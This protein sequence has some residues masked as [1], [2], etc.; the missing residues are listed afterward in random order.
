[1]STQPNSAIMEA[2]GGR[3]PGG[4][5]QNIE[6]IESDPHVQAREMIVE[7]EQPGSGRTVR[8]AGSP[9]KLTQ[10]PSGVRRRAPLLD[11]DRAAILSGW[12]A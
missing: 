1:M 3:V 11:E 9:I 5:V 2:L 10:T 4:P 7:V 6:D 12:E 8:I